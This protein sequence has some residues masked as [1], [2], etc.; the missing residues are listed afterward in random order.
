MIKHIFFDFNGTLINDID[1]CIELLND[2]LKGQNK[3]PVSKEKYKEIFT[4]PIKEYYL[5]AGVDFNIESY[6][7][8][9]IKFIECYQPRSL[10]CGLFDGVV[11]TLKYLKQKGIHQYILSA[12][13]RNN[14]LEQC[15]YYQID[16][17][18]DA[19]LG[20]DD[21]HASSKVEVAINFMKMT[22]INP[23]EAVF[24]G[25]TLHDFEVANA[26]GVMCIL[27]SCGH[28]SINVLK[29]SNVKIISD[30]SVI[31]SN[32]DELFD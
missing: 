27:V 30:V 16:N 17:L 20:I 18:F 10:Q 14:L 23:S 29:K 2:L 32:F 28:Q 19:I 8:L 9:A 31:R 3:K 13:E 21:I 26:M 6:E 4:F 25:D 7:S 22:G 15:K 24:I 5:R 12:S 11:D 1:L